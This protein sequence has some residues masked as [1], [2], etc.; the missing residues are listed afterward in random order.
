MAGLGPMCTQAYI[1]RKGRQHA[2]VDPTMHSHTMA[3]RA[4]TLVR[5]RPLSPLSPNYTMRIKRF[6]SIPYRR[7]PYRRVP[8]GR[9]RL[10][11]RRLDEV[12]SSATGYSWELFML[13]TSI[14]IS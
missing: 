4:S 13:T 11:E 6:E 5:L 10:D 12:H 2:S 3:V 8:I 9:V 14:C 1:C 7:E